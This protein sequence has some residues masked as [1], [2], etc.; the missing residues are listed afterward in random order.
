MAAPTVHIA[1]RNN[2]I[3]SFLTSLEQVRKTVE[4]VLSIPIDLHYIWLDAPLATVQLRTGRTGRAPTFEKADRD[5][6]HSLGE[7]V[8]CILGPVSAPVIHKNY[9]ANPTFGV[10]ESLLK[11]RK[12][13]S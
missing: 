13:M 7:P 9:L 3:C 6:G 8:D 5:R 4:G 10:P 2:Q 12:E 11:R 1:G